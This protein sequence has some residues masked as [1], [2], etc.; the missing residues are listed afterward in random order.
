MSKA[1]AAARH[2]DAMIAA[3]GRDANG[4]TVSA[5]AQRAS[6]NVTDAAAAAALRQK[7]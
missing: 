4:N 3:T 6:Q 2:E 5:S 1:A 7:I